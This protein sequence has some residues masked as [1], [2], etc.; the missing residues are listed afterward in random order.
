ME[1]TLF[2][3]SRRLDR[4]VRRG[5][6]MAATSLAFGAAAQTARAPAP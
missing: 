3:I 4:G 2:S 6:L 5:L 1:T